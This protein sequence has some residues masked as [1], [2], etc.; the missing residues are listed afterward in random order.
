MPNGDWLCREM[1]K[2]PKEEVKAWKVGKGK[3][4]TEIDAFLTFMVNI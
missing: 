4:E 2:E 3:V 1:P